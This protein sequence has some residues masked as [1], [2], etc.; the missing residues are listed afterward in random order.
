M[1]VAK[2]F[3]VGLPIALGVAMV[4]AGAVN[5]AG[6]AEMSIPATSQEPVASVVGARSINDHLNGTARRCH[7]AVAIK[8]PVVLGSPKAR[9]SSAAPV[10]FDIA[11][12]VQKITGVKV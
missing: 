8:M 6:L 5:F 3:A 12:Q 7:Q 2:L 4:G 10:N 9:A 1:P 11:L